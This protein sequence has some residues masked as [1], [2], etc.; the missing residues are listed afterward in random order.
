MVERLVDLLYRSGRYTEAEAALAR[1]P[2]GTPLKGRLGQMAAELALRRGD[3]KQAEEL[4]D[5]AADSKNSRDQLWR[6]LVLQRAGQ[7]GKAEK[8]LRQAVALDETSPEAWLGLIAVLAYLQIDVDAPSLG[9]FAWPTVLLIGGLAAGLLLRVVIRPF[10]AFGA[11]RRRR[12]AASELRRRV[13][14]V[15]DDLVLEP[16]RAELT[17]YGRLSDAVHRLSR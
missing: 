3:L 17:A 6:G 2:E 4:A 7:P 12:R 10:V 8:A 11:A 16:L 13:D 5:K 1:L 14:A 15:G 9:P